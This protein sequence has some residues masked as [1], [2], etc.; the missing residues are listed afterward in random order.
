MPILSLSL[1]ELRTRRSLKWRTYSPDVLPLWV[2]EMDAGMHP[3]VRRTLLDAADRG[4]TGYPHGRAY[5]QAF[6]TMARERWG[7]VLEEARQV[8]IAGD[9]MNG[10]L[11]VLEATTDPGDAVVINPPIYP[12]FRQVVAGYRRRIV[13]APLNPAGRL[14]LEALEAAF[15]GPERPRAHLLCSP[16]NPTGA[17][18]TPEELAAVAELASRFGVRVIVDEIHAPLVDPGTTFTPMLAVPGGERAVAVTSAGKA[19]NL[20]AFKAG[21]I[22][23]GAEAGDVLADLPPLATQS[24]GHMA[25]MV[26]TTAM[27]EAQ[28][29]IDDLV[30]E[31]RANKELL[32]GLLAE[33]VPTARYLPTEGTYL[34]WVD[35]TACGLSDPAREFRERG[36]VAFSAGAAF[37]RAHQQWVRINLATSP[38]VITEAV[39]RMAGVV[40]G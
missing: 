22:I 7:W 17:V 39:S 34:A 37:G 36:L 2:A 3:A 26:H 20:A 18:H 38:E 15:A 4:D 24:T 31:I 30:V 14:D 13:E 10:I 11:A 28:D 19:W 1:A 27:L 40:A 29:W 25:S 32:A 35:C 21:L 23:G 12:P 6:A 16:H 9:V 33:Q 8:K 5:A